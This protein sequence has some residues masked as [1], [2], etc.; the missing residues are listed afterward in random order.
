MADAGFQNLM[1]KATPMLW[2]PLIGITDSLYFLNTKYL[3]LKLM[4]G[5]DFITTEFVTP[6]N[7][8]A[9][10]AKILWMGNL[11][12]TARRRQG[13]LYSITAPA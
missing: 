8:A 9:K 12:C 6:D 4:S 3:R 2:E 5:A 1:F 10:T 7:Q 13:T 11:C